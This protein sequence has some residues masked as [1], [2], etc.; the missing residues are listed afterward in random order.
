MK[1]EI[2]KLGL[3]FLTIV[4]SIFLPACGSDDS[5][6]PD[7]PTNTSVEKLLIGSW[8]DYS[9]DEGLIFKT[10]GEGVETYYTANGKYEDENEFFYTVKDD[11][12]TII[13]KDDYYDDIYDPYVLKIYSIDSKRLILEEDDGDTL[14][15]QREGSDDINTD[16]NDYNSLIKRCVDVTQSYHDYCWNYSINSTL[17]KELK[18]HKVEYKILHGIKGETDLAYVDA[19]NDINY[20]YIYNEYGDKAAITFRIPY[21]FYY[22]AEKVINGNSYGDASNSFYLN[23]YLALKKKSSETSLSNSEKALLADVIDILYDD[24]IRPKSLWETRLVVEIDGKSYFPFE[25]FSIGAQT[26]GA[27][28]YTIDGETYNMI[29]VEGGKNMPTFYMMQTELPS[30]SD[31]YFGNVLISKLNRDGNK[32][33]SRTELTHFLNELREAT[34]IQFRLPTKEEWQYAANGGSNNSGFIY[35]GSNVINDVAWYSGNSDKKAHDFACKQPNALGLYD[36]SGNYAEVCY[37]E[38]SSDGKYYGVDG[39]ICGGSWNDESGKCKITSWEEGKKNGR[40]PGSD[41]K[42]LGNFDVRYNA[43]RLVYSEGE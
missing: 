9:H 11:V 37:D 23:S 29:R 15:Y 4:A 34:G 31:I 30:N 5:D 33:V 12:I 39:P 35:S 27:I 25:P 24:E 20:E 17:E 43:V 41:L 26:V 8:M 3:L 21:Y 19:G 18:G 2:K 10:G 32:G 38:I 6:N 13:F 40:I 28:S 1:R 16:E 14:V 42:E 22:L 36:M 7:N